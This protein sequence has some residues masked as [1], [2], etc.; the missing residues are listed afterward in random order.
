MMQSFKISYKRWLIDQKFKSISRDKMMWKKTF[1]AGRVQ[2]LWL[3]FVHNGKHCMI[4]SHFLFFIMLNL[5]C[6]NKYLNL[7]IK[8][9]E[10]H[11]HVLSSKCSVF[12][13]L[14]DNKG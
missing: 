13:Q 5:H 6:Y 10:V 14:K 11:Q 4:D 8:N 2:T 9:E 3:F 1:K 7:M 12:T